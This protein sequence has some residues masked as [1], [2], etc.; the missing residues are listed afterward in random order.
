MVTNE[1]W[2]CT[3]NTRYLLLISGPCKFSA[4]RSVIVSGPDALDTSFPQRPYASKMAIKS[5]SVGVLRDTAAAAL[6]DIVPLTARRCR[7]IFR[8]RS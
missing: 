8:I 4:Y 3:P 2:F 5:G 6:A 7:T 1:N